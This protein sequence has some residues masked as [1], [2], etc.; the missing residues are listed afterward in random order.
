MKTI[1]GLLFIILLLLL[2]I[3]ACSSSR[4]GGDIKDKGNEIELTTKDH[5]VK[6]IK[7]APVEDT[8][9]LFTVHPVIFPDS[10]KY[11]DARIVVITKKETDQ[12]KAT[13]GSIVAPENKKGHSIARS[14]IKR[15]S[16]I[17]ADRT[18]QKQIQKLIDLNSRGLFPVI[19]LSMT[20]LRVS[21]L[22]YKKSKVFL[23]GELGMQYLVK[24]IE[25]L[26]ENHP[27]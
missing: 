13:Y 18:A 6:A 7:M 5:Y 8:F 26:E 2:V 11:L 15:Y 4:S 14:L 24:K 3:P 22:S 17:A 23:S 1:R 12:L 16:L 10:M 21:E 25:I 19:K 20:G 27:L 9:V